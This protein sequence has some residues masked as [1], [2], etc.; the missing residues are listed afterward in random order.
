M[1]VPA[2]HLKFVITNLLVYLD[3]DALGFPFIAKEIPRE[4]L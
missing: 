4:S 2:R 3:V 1:P